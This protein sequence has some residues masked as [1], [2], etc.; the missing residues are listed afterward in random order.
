M[1]NCENM[2]R[3]LIE[4]GSKL[5]NYTEQI[6]IRDCKFFDKVIIHAN[7]VPLDVLEAIMAHDEIWIDTFF[8]GDSGRLLDVMILKA[9]EL[10]IK[11]KTIINVNDYTKVMWHLTDTYNNNFDALTKNNINF[12]YGDDILYYKYMTA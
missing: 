12:I 1:L 11:N 2:K 7:S 6:I 8:I 3:V 5:S 10:E 4:I 9:I